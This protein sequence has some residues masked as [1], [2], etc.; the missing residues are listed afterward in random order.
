ADYE[1]ALDR[2][3]RESQRLR[4]IVEDLLWLARVDAEPAQP[5][6][7]SID[8]REVARSSVERFTAVAGSSNQQ[9]ELAA[10]GQPG[11][12]LN[13]IAPT[14]WLEKLA[15]TL[16]DNA[17]RY[18]P[19][20]ARIRVSA[21]TSPDSSRVVLRVEDD[22]PGID[23]SDRQEVVHRF[24]RATTTGGGH[25]LGLAIADSVARR[26][27]GRLTIGESE[28][29]GTLAEVSWPKAPGS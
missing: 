24:R 21:C 1:E 9:L 4:R 3:G 16:I 29:G 28:L 27:G 20:G 13:V 10:E 25:G 12:A 6:R 7:E 11:G 22:G 26:T 18:S 17:A 23:P 19:E 15:G 8:L 2:V 5:S 14:D